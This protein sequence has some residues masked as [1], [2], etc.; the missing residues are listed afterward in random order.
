MNW[1]RNAGPDA[2]PALYDPVLIAM[3]LQAFTLTGFERIE[4]TD[5]VQSWLVGLV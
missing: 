2:L 1:Q 5:Y 4:G 3:S